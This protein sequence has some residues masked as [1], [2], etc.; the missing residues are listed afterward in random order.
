MILK[1][2]R[3]VI[4]ISIFLLLT[5]CAM[6]NTV[7]LPPSFW[8]QKQEKIVVARASGMTPQLYQQGR[9]GLIDYMINEAVSSSLQKRLALYD[10]S[11]YSKIQN[12]FYRQ[13]AIKEMNVSNLDQTIDLTKLNY[14]NRDVSRFADRDFSFLASKFHA[15]KLLLIRLNAIGGLRLYYGFIPISDPVAYCDIQGDLIDLK[16]NQIIW[17]AHGIVKIPI[18]GAWSQPPNYPNF[19]NSLDWAVNSASKQLLDDFFN[20]S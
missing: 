17:R 5:A 20:R 7:S 2:M 6:T 14:V 9:E 18:S 12:A 4:F 10:M 13:L 1:F 15:D 19:I 3:S 8:Q 11:W 16:T